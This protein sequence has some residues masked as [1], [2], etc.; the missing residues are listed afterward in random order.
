MHVE[1]F[2]FFHLF[3]NNIQLEWNEQASSNTFK[4]KYRN[5]PL[6]NYRL[7]IQ[8]LARYIYIF[9]RVFG[10]QI[11]GHKIYEYSFANLA[12]GRN[13]R[14]M[15]DDDNGARFIH[16]YA[17]MNVRIHLWHHEM[18]RQKNSQVQV[19]HPSWRTH[20]YFAIFLK[21]NP[22]PSSF[23]FLYSARSIKIWAFI[24]HT[25]ISYG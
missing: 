4:S 21:K 9:I 20:E 18:Q 24:P 25:V 7:S 10:E 14:S 1:A 6:S 19:K 23:P 16:R 12:S 15:H 17:A 3:F 2:Y 5:E 8:Y 13:R 11:F 22:H